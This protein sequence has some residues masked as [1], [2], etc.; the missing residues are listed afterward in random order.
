M[1][2]HMLRV[3][4]L[5]TL[6]ALAAGCAGTLRV[7][8]ALSPLLGDLSNAKII[9][10]YAGGNQLLL[11][12][13]LAAAPTENSEAKLVRTATLTNPAGPAPTGTATLEIERKAGVSEEVIIVDLDGLPFP[14]TCR[15]VLDGR[16]VLTFSGTDDGEVR[17]KLTR[18][19]TPTQGASGGSGT[20][21]ARR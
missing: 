20:S 19:T 7:E 9:E 21:N 2:L 18:R 12:G 10:V 17:L 4:L 8:S 5:V 11:R 13:E 6:A 15:L 3:S 16:D 14:G 1:R